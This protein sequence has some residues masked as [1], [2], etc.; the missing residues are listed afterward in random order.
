MPTPDGGARGQQRPQLPRQALC[1]FCRC[2]CD[3]TTCAAAELTTAR[4]A[5]KP[6]AARCPVA[7]RRRAR[8]AAT[9]RC[10]LASRAQD[11][12]LAPNPVAQPSLAIDSIARP[13]P[14]L[15]FI[16]ITHGTHTHTGGAS[17]QIYHWISSSNASMMHKMQAA[18]RAARQ[19]TQQYAQRKRNASHSHYSRITPI[20]HTSRHGRSHTTVRIERRLAIVCA[21]G[22]SSRRL[23]GAP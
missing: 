16:F 21:S 10:L 1:A 14:Y 20:T 2:T 9:G 5:R 22:C 15:M 11:G 23:F 8:A 18:T 17:Q 13:C 19:N 4:V 7:G 3:L 12:A 6:L